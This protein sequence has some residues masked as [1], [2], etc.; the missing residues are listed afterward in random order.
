MEKT[1][2]TITQWEYGCIRDRRTEKERT[3]QRMEMCTLKRTWI[4]L[5]LWKYCVILLEYSICRGKYYSIKS[6]SALIKQ[7]WMILYH[8]MVFIIA[9]IHRRTLQGLV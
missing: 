1:V 6:E 9:P 2:L 7:P 3:I 5:S 8:A 4:I